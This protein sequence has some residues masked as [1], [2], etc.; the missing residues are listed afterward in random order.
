MNNRRTRRNNQYHNNGTLGSSYNYNYNNTN[1]DYESDTAYLSDMPTK[2]PPPLRS[3]EELNLAVCRRHNP[4]VTNIL[5]LANYAVIY[6]FSPATTTWEKINIE[7]TLFVCQLSPGSLGEERYT[8]L[9]LNRRGLNNFDCPLTGSENVEL[10]DEF[11]ILKQDKESNP[12]SAQQ[13]NYTVY[14]IWIYSEPNTSTDETRTINAKIISDCAV[15]AGG[16]LKEAKARVQAMRQDGLHVAAAAAESQAAPTEELQGGI[17]MGRTMSLKDMFGQQRA[18]DDGFSV[19]AHHEQ[20]QPQHQYPPQYQP[21]QPPQPHVQ[22]YPQHQYPSAP[23]YP[24]MYPNMPMHQQPGV[25][26]PHVQSHVQTQAPPQVQPRQDVLGD[27]F[28]RAGLEPQ[29]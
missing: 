1:T 13:T 20:P 2:P 5:S 29:Q 4:E 27:L 23:G 3:N 15:R 10:T 11:V 7:G 6:T 28:R 16:S 18:Q 24:P 14:G 12:T 17:P 26:Q 8:A 25:P 19:R 22:A 9:L 21:P